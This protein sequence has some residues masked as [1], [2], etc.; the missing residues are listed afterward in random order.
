MVGDRADVTEGVCQELPD[1]ETALG[2]QEERAA[3]R[4]DSGG[5]ADQRLDGV[6]ALGRASVDRR[7]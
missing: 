1:R 3:P 6:E 5:V 2:D 7:V 4:E